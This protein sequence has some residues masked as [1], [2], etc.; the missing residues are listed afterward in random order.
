[1]ARL[2][3]QVHNATHTTPA[4]MGEFLRFQPTVE[5]TIDDAAKLMGVKQV[6]PHDKK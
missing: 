6:K 4:E 3:T 5:T 1:M 2:S